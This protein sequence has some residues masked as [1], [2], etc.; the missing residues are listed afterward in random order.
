MIKKPSSNF[1]NPPNSIPNSNDYYNIGY[2]FYQNGDTRKAIDNFRKAIRNDKFNSKAYYALAL[3][4]FK[5]RDNFYDARVYVQNAIRID[6]NNQKYQVLL[7]K[8]QGEIDYKNRGIIV[9]EYKRTCNKCGKVW[10]SLIEREKELERKRKNYG[11]QSCTFATCNW[12]AMTQSNRNQDATIDGLDRLR[13]CP[14]CQ[15][16]DY[17]EEIV[18]HDV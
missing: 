14:E 7:Q 3:C 16:K 10:F 1:S 17:T 5:Q 13:S 2:N 12:G 6:P 15:S 8:I 18:S 9:K 4:Y 11:C